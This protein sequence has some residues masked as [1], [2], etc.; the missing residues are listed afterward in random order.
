MGA[1]SPLNMGEDRRDGS[2]QPTSEDLPAL[3]GIGRSTHAHI[4]GQH[5]RPVAEKERS[6]GSERW[7]ESEEPI[8]PTRPG[9]AGGGKGLW[10]E[11]RL[12]ET[13]VRRSA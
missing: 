13:R 6:V 2:E 9:N 10:F 5:G 1:S 12:D 8:V 11:M 3:R 7:Q 4:D